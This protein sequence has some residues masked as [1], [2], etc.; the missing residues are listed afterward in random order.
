LQ[1]CLERTVALDNVRLRMRDW[2]GLDGPLLHVPDPLVLEPSPLI[3]HVAALVA[4]RWRVLSILPRPNT[5]YQVHLIDIVG[6]LDQ[7][8][9]VDATLVAEGTACVTALL[10]AAWYPHYLGRLVL[11]QP[12]GAAE[13]DSLEARALRDCPPDLSRLRVDLACA[14]YE[15]ASAEEVAATLP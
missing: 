5:P 12:R 11:V 15:A 14:L 6:V 9:F 8:G 2:P 1:V 7:F 3:E 13:G 4:P 10:L